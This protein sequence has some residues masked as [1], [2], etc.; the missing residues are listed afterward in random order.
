MKNTVWAIIIGIML[1]LS[2][3]LNHA[4]WTERQILLD[5]QLKRRSANVQLWYG[6]RMRVTA[7]CP[8]SKCCGKWADGVTASGHKIQPGD[9]FVAASKEFAFGTI[10]NVPGYGSV[11]VLDRGGAIKGDR[12]DLYFDT[13]QAALN[14]GVQHLLVRFEP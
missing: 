8:C 12:L 5:D 3:V 9:K 4:L 6:Q 1:G 11:P 13:H 7:Y 14:W 10:V 2:L